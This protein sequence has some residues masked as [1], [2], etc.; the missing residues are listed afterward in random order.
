M[1]NRFIQGKVWR[2]RN[3]LKPMPLLSEKTYKQTRELF[4]PVSDAVEATKILNELKKNG[5]R[6]ESKTTHSPNDIVPSGTLIIYADMSQTEPFNEEIENIKKL[7]DYIQEQGG[8]V[9]EKGKQ[10]SQV[11]FFSR[12][13]GR[14]GK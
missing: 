12:L 9:P 3:G 5:I 6:V 8:K 2:W 1:P 13:F 10:T 14:G 4:L 11:S 7:E